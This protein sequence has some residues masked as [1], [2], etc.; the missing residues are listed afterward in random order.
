MITTWRI[1]SQGPSYQA[2]DLSGNGGLHTSGRWNSIGS[3]VVYTASNISLATLETVVHLRA[4]SLPLNRYLV[5]IEI[6]D[7]VWEVRRIINESTVP[8]WNSIPASSYSR[9]FGDEWLAQRTELLL[10]VPSAITPEE[11]N[12]LINPLHPDISKISASKVRLF[13]YDARIKTL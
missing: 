6:P 2:E 8:E 11:S 5:R 3:R 4:N 9:S 7:D 10:Q 12:I 1:A 13:V